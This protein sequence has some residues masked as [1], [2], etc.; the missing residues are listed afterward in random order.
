MHLDAVPADILAPWLKGA[1][2]F[3]YRFKYVPKSKA[4]T[5]MPPP[6]PAKP[7]RSLSTHSIGL[8]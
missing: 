3:F 7:S 2:N 4:L 1:D 8:F 6:S 5:A